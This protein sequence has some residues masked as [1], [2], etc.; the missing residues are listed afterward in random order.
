MF[1][2]CVTVFTNQKIWQHHVRVSFGNHGFHAG[3][4][5]VSQFCQRPELAQEV[6]MITG[7]SGE[8][9]RLGRHG[10]PDTVL[11][12]WKQE[13]EVSRG[14]CSHVGNAKRMMNPGRRTR[15]KT[16][17]GEQGDTDVPEANEKG[18]VEERTL[19]LSKVAGGRF[20]SLSVQRLLHVMCKRS[21]SDSFG[22][23]P[24]GKR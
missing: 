14:G 9:G 20:I 2:C 3:C 16:R 12:S 22:E 17:T 8:R 1:F 21:L 13:C 24:A 23:T 10:V 4:T 7:T 19:R 15:R 11:G 18:R 5:S 6:W